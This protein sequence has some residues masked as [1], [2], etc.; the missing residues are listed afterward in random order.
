MNYWTIRL[1]VEKV[2]RDEFLEDIRSLEPLYT[3][4]LNYETA[5]GNRHAVYV[6]S[7]D[8]NRVNCLNSWGSV[9]QTPRI[10]IEKKGNIFYRVFCNTDME[11]EEEREE[12]GNI[13][14]DSEVENYSDWEDYTDWVDPEYNEEDVGIYFDDEVPRGYQRFLCGM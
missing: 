8:R 2:E 11:E 6:E 10:P 3:Y 13:E 1:S 5:Q 14:E 7:C 9:E 4:I 12:A